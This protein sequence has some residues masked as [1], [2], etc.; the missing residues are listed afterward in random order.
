MRES[1]SDWEEQVK[2]NNAQTAIKQL[3]D[4]KVELKALNLIQLKNIAQKFLESARPARVLP[5][6]PEATTVERFG[7]QELGEVKRTIS[8]PVTNVNTITYSIEDLDFESN[9]HYLILAPASFGKTYAFW[10][11][12]SNRLENAKETIPLYIPLGA[13]QSRD[14]FIAYVNDIDPRANFNALLNDN[15]IIWVL[16]GW[17]EFS[18][19]QDSSERLKVIRNLS[20][21]KVLANARKTTSNDAHFALWFLDPLSESDVDH[22]LR[23]SGLPV[24]LTEAKIREI[25]RLPLVLSLYIL[26]KGSKKT[27]GGLIASLHEHLSNSVL[28]INDPIYKTVAT[29]IFEID[30]RSLTKFNTVFELAAKGSGIEK[31]FNTLEALGSLCGQGD[32]IVPLHDLYWEWLAGNGLIQNNMLD[33]ALKN[34]KSLECVEL[35]VE[36][37]TLTCAEQIER[38]V[39]Q[40]LNLAG[41]L[42]KG[43]NPSDSVNANAIFD[44]HILSHLNHNSLAIRFRAATAML[45]ASKY[46]QLLEILNIFSELRKNKIYQLDFELLDVDKL[47]EYRGV[48]SEWIGADGTEDVLELIAKRDGQRW[49]KWLEQMA[50]QNKISWVSASYTAL[51]CSNNIPDW[52]FPH[53]KSII[54]DKAWKL[55]VIAAKGQNITLATWIA[56]QYSE[57]V[58]T[59]SGKFIELNRVLKK[60]GT[61]TTY[62]LLFELFPSMSKTGQECLGFLIKDLGGHWVAKFQ[63]LA[64]SDPKLKGRHHYSLLETVSLEV[65][66]EVARQWIKHGPSELGWRVLIARY[67]NAMESELKA[68]LPEFFTVEADQT[69]LSA[70]RYLTD[71]SEDTISTIWDKMRSPVMPNTM[72]N[73]LNAVCLNTK[74]IVDVVKWIAKSPQTLPNYH[75]CEFSKKLKEWSTKN[76]MSFGVKSELGDE[77]FL[78]WALRVKLGSENGNMDLIMMQTF[79]NFDQ[80]YFKQ[81]LL[82]VVDEVNLKSLAESN[83][84]SEY[85]EQIFQKLMSSSKT[86]P[87][88]LRVFEKAFETFPESEM[89]KLFD[90]QEIEFQTLLYWISQSPSPMHRNFH[91]VLIQ[92]VLESTIDM[93]LYSYLARLLSIHPLSVLKTLLKQ[94]IRIKS[95]ESFW[96]IRTME[97]TLGYSLIDEKGNM[98]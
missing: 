43:V 19:G 53:L 31:P 66:D 98:T 30:E 61:E 81:F 23:A 4:P 34:L 79:S 80:K 33:K 63:E 12:T 2:V 74:G 25:L 73:I 92:K 3:P 94:N 38:V 41:V 22:V 97:Q 89:F 58:D 83:K 85:D 77:H 13:I 9:Q 51:S 68:A 39:T 18:S 71:I 24:N 70:M 46:E 11:Y 17:S 60:C 75:F 29:R 35:S 26:L 76:H 42:L 10:S 84:L 72:Y 8:S 36:S 91:S 62:Q 37:G 65:T 82:S 59:G 64:F 88:V 86:A 52:C 96:F 54:K 49:T 55:R 56:H 95:E 67:G 7:I 32:K 16:D 78:D 87:S 20:S 47:Y 90:I 57:I 50:H 14:E 45:R 48:L 93:H 40:N 6:F 69:A 21:S 28:A 44:Q 1:K 5:L 15:R 27:L